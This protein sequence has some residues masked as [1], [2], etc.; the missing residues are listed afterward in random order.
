M[1]KPFRVKELV[2]RVSAR[3]RQ[4]RQFR[5]VREHAERREAEARAASAEAR[6]RA[7]MIDILH[8]ITD[9]LKPDEI[10]QI[11]ARRVAR[12]LSVTRCSMVLDPIL[13]YDLGFR[14]Y[15]R[16]SESRNSP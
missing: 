5:A 4:S 9:T 6:V 2:A 7:E 14:G 10:Y 12:V 3:L 15:F 8:E 13:G 1:A 11:L 16:L